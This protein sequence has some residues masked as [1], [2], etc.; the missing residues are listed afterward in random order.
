[1]FPD[2]RLSS[3][4]THSSMSLSADMPSTMLR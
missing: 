3:G 2:T 4:G 1:M